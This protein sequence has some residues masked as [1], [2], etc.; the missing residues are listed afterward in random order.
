MFLKLEE[1][2]DDTVGSTQ[3]NNGDT[4]QK[5]DIIPVS[6]TLLKQTNKQVSGSN[7]YFHIQSVHH[8]RYLILK[9]GHSTLDFINYFNHDG[10]IW[11][12]HQATARRRRAAEN[13]SII[14]TIATPNTSNLIG[15]FAVPKASTS[16]LK[17]SGPQSALKL[18]GKFYQSTGIQYI[19]C[20]KSFQPNF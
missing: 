14:S 15:K 19:N 17:E 1:N 4:K 11:I 20:F 18:C 9:W 16:E 2:V 3:C 5:W 13:K 7:I 8:Q 12:Q 10:A 6:E